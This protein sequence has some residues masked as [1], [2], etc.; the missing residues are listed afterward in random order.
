M[1]RV[2]SSLIGRGRGALFHVHDADDEL[3][4]CVMYGWDT[5]RA[6]YLFG[7]GS[8]ARSAPWQGTLAHW[9]AFQ[10]LAQ[11]HGV[12]E[13][14]LEGVNSP[15]RGWFKLSFGGDLR[16][17]YRLRLQRS[18]PAAEVASLDPEGACRSL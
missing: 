2:I 15:Q 8:D 9:A 13:V 4:Y 10:H 16:P 6:Y 1:G 18:S 12:R 3:L 17:Y 11:E 7:A 14:D 5:K